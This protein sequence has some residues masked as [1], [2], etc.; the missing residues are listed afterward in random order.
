MEWKV[1]KLAAFDEESSTVREKFRRRLQKTDPKAAQD[2]G[3]STA[4]RDAFHLHISRIA[5]RNHADALFKLNK[6]A[7]AKAKVSIDFFVVVVVVA[8]ATAALRN[9]CPAPVGVGS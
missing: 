3:G 6:E 7:Q 5:A 9:N 1:S 2:E 4:L 8:A